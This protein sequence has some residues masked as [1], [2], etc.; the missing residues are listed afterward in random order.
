MSDNNYQLDLSLEELE[1]LLDFVDIYY[2]TQLSPEVYSK[3]IKLFEQSLID[4]GTHIQLTNNELKHILWSIRYL[5]D[6][7]YSGDEELSK[8]YEKNNGNILE[9][10]IETKI[11]KVLNQ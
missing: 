5:S 7:H 6:M 1:S 11:L 8:E 9:K 4:R 10:S 2:D 3:I